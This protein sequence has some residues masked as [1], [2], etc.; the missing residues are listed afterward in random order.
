MEVWEWP[1][2][3]QALTNLTVQLV[4]FQCPRPTYPTDLQAGIGSLI[5]LLMYS[6]RPNPSEGLPVAEEAI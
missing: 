4:C 6:R 1:W 5:Q 3:L 2:G